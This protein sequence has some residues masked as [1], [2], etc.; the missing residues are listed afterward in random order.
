MEI[1]DQDFS[2]LGRGSFVSGTFKLK[3]PTHLFSVTEGE[4]IMLDEADLSIERDGEFKGK[5]ICHNVDIYGEFEGILESTGKVTVYPPATITGKIQAKELV[6]YPG[7]T[8]NMEGHT[9]H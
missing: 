7:A 4:I 3:G 2:F 6:I 8:V 1:K 9:V 5:L